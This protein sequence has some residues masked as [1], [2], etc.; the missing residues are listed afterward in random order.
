MKLL[1]AFTKIH[2]YL[3][4]SGLKPK[5]QRFEIECPASL[6]SYMEREKIQYQLVPL[7]I[8]RRNLIENTNGTFKDHFITGITSVD[9]KM[10]LYLWCRLLPL[11]FMTL[12]ILRQSRIHPIQQV[13]GYWCN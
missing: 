3:T 8:H 10:P 1:Q 12:N 9:Q 5:W 2:T 13:I 4:E 11:A 6:K 7:Q